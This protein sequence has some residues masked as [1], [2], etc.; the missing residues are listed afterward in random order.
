MMMS[1]KVINTPSLLSIDQGLQL[2]KSLSSS[3]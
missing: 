2:W 1:P 3:M